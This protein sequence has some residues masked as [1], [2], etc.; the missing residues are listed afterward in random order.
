MM[1]VTAKMNNLQFETGL[2]AGGESS[3]IY[4]DPSRIIRVVLVVVDQNAIPAFNRDV[5]I[6]RRRIRKVLQ[7]L[8]QDQR[9]SIL[10]L[11]ERKKRWLDGR[12]LALASN[13]VAVDGRGSTPFNSVSLAMAGSVREKAE[14]KETMSTVESSLS[15]ELRLAPGIT[16]VLPL[17]RGLRRMEEVLLRRV[18]GTQNVQARR[19][20]ISLRFLA[21]KRNDPCQE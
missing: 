9:L 17:G 2:T 14:A 3:Y 12:S 21:K 10:L 1:D 18:P 6:H 19:V 16:H 15:K 5:R 4:K 7:I 13:S 8:V 20:D 11:P